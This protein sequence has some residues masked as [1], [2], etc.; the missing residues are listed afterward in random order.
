MVLWPDNCQSTVDLYK[1]IYDNLTYVVRQCQKKKKNVLNRNLEDGA[2]LR[3]RSS[4]ESKFI[5]WVSL[6]LERI[7]LKGVSRHRLLY[8]MMDSAL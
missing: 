8:N 5:F 6:N 1:S 3:F 2:T 4:S 7:S